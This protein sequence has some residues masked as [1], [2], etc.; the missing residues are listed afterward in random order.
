MTTR[1]WRVSNSSSSTGLARPDAEKRRLKVTV[2][3]LGTAFR[4]FAA[5]PGVQTVG[6]TLAEAIA[7]VAGHEVQITCAGR[8]DAGVHARGQVVHCDV[9]AEVDPDALRRSVNRMLGPDIVARSIEEAAPGF[10]A[11]RSA[12][13]RRYAY[14]ILNTQEPSPFLAA[15]AWHIE[16]PLDIHALELAADPVIG[17]HDFSAFCRRPPDREEGEPLTRRVF[18]ARW[19]ALPGDLVRFEI[20]AG[21]FCHQMVRSLVGTMVEMGRG[22]RKAGEMAAILR[23]RNRAHA[24]SP[25]P[26]HGLCLEEVAY[27]Q[28]M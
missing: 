24:A 6:G 10:D 14:T 7:K 2:A 27:P 26:P 9:S 8:T 3:Y 4:G 12:I 20:A 19:R 17:E 22:R 21:A 18:D 28:G 15:I 16:H 25:A 1:L 11:R 23:S 13:G 5:Q